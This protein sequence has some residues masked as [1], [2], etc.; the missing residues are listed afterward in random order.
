MRYSLWQLLNDRGIEIP[1]FQR[2]YAQGRLDKATLRHDFLHQLVIALTRAE[3]TAGNLDFVY[4]FG[5][6]NK[7]LKPLDGQQRLTTLWLL[8]WYLAVKTL[9]GEKLEQALKFLSRFSYRT[10]HS[11]SDFIASLCTKKNIENL[12]LS[13]NIADAIRDSTWFVKSWLQDPTVTGMLNTIKGNKVTDKP[14]NTPNLSY[15][16]G[17]QPALEEFSRERLKEFWEL[18]KDDNCPIKF[19]HLTIKD[20]EVKSADLL[21][22]KMNARGK[23]LS[24]YENFKAQWLDSIKAIDK[25]EY[26]NISC[27]IDNQWSD[28]FWDANLTAGIDQRKMAFFTRFYLYGLVNLLISDERLKSINLENQAKL[29]GESPLYDKEVNKDFYC[30]GFQ[31]LDEFRLS[32][33]KTSTISLITQTANRE[34]TCIFDYVKQFSEDLSHPYSPDFS[35]IPK[36]IRRN[37][38]L[39]KDSDGNYLVAKLSMKEQAFFFSICLY[40]VESNNPNK[41]ALHRWLRVCANIIENTNQDSSRQTHLNVIKLISQLG[42]QSLSQKGIK[43]C[44]N[45]LECLKDKSF[46]RKNQLDDVLW[47]EREKAIKILENS[48]ISEKEIEEVEGYAFFKGAIRFLFLNA[49]GEVDWT[50]FKRK[51]S[52]AKQL[53]CAEGLTDDASV[54]DLANRKLISHCDDWL[55]QIEWH[56]YILSHKAD[57]WRKI[58]I[59]YDFCEP[60]HK[61]LT[62]NSFADPI[63]LKETDIWRKISHELL[64]NGTYL[65]YYNQNRVNDYYIRWMGGILP[66][67]GMC[68]YLKGRQTESFFLA[69]TWLI[70]LSNCPDFNIIKPNE[71]F[72]YSRRSAF[73]IVYRGY[74]FRFQAWGWIDMY[75]DGNKLEDID[76]LKGKCVLQTPWIDPKNPD[77][78]IDTLKSEF[79]RCIA[80][81]ELWKST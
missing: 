42:K 35:F 20:I 64:V 43:G 53:F 3:D 1:V 69:S 30:F 76:A 51:I 16:N 31:S 34:L 59:S 77:V 52:T 26:F 79:N 14:N 65:K 71:D 62:T 67:N 8:H 47:E 73:D 48:D 27:L 10:R 21:Y 18:L 45:I 44:D 66:D 81:Y 50:N 11:S 22:V 78:G 13:S 80:N 49:S 2:D 70:E 19:D 40:F 32:I 75:V 25:D 17:I 54:D 28:L 46:D 61:L 29:L 60:V 72:I 23:P 24:A 37:N 7:A 68:L 12:N 33:S 57:E 74:I 36:L 56:Y 9:E 39:Q 5:D 6:E 41:L 4:S 55:K 15:P 63:R 38:G 58:L